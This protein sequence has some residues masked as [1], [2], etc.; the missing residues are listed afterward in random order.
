MAWFTGLLISVL[1]KY[2][3]AIQIYDALPDD[4]PEDCFVVTAATRGHRNVVGSWY[5]EEQRRLL[6]Q[7]LLTFWRFESRLKTS[8][9]NIHR[10][11]RAVYNRIGPVFVRMIVF[12]W[13]ADLVYLLL[14]PAEIVARNLP[15]LW[16]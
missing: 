4:P 12:R 3:L 9:P 15:L 2:P 7:Q 14:K 10:M 6:N 1:I 8:L 5:D 11:I 13:Q 16:R